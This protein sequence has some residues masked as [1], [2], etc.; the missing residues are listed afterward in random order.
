[1]NLNIQKTIN[2]NYSFLFK[3]A[4]KVFQTCDLDAKTTTNLL[5]GLQTLLGLEMPLDS[6][7]SA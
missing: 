5:D 1:M 2:L 6:P 7:G 4:S 3:G